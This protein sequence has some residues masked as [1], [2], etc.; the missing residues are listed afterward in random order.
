MKPLEPADYEFMDQ[1]IADEMWRDWEKTKLGIAEVFPFS[2]AKQ[3]GEAL[4]KS[5]EESKDKS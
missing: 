5:E 2:F 3:W 4:E 1:I